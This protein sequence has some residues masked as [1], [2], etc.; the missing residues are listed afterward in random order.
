MGRYLFCWA[1]AL[2][3][4]LAVVLPTIDKLQAKQQAAVANHLM[5][6]EAP[7]AGRQP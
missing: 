2:G 3:I 7:G 1:L 4:L 5:D 6:L